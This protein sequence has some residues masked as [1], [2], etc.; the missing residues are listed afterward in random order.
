MAPSAEAK[1]NGGLLGSWN[2]QNPEEASEFADIKSW[3]N[4]VNNMS[5]WKLEICYEK[6]QLYILTKILDISTLDA[7]GEH[8]N[9]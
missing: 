9:F 8:I 5:I 2:I 4:L 3:M 6:K 1:I 7:F